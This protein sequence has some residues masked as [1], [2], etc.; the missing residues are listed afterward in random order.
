MLGGLFGTARIGPHEGSDGIE[1][2]EEEMRVHPRLQRRD[3]RHCCPASGLRG[4]GSVPRGVLKQGAR[5][6]RHG[7]CGK[8]DETRI[9]QRADQRERQLSAEHRAQHHQQRGAA[10]S[11]AGGEADGRERDENTIR[12]RSI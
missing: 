11:D 10:E 4:P 7:Q 1:R 9:E 12:L 6:A 3:L 2:V 5:R 8:H